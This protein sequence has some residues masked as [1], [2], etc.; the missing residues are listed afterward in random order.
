M[1]YGPIC[2]FIIMYFFIPRFDIA[3]APSVFE[4]V[5][6]VYFSFMCEDFFFYWSHRTLHL[7]YF[8]K[9]IH[10]IHHE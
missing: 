3:S 7:P 2:L 9:R 1:V 8:Y 4:Y 5:L 6:Q 10:K